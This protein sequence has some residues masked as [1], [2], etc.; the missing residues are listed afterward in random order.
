MS[1]GVLPYYTFRAGLTTT[2]VLLYLPRAGPIKLAVQKNALIG[3][4]H[5]TPFIDT[6]LRV[7]VIA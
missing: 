1:V 7:P 6:L 3:T 2:C 4:I 5:Y